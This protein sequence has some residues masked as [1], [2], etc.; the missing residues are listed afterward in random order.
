MH[1]DTH[2][3]PDELRLTSRMRPG[4]P[5]PFVDCEPRRMQRGQ[6]VSM[7]AAAAMEVAAMGVATLVVLV[8][9]AAAL[10]GRAVV[11]MQT[12]VDMDEGSVRWQRGGIRKPAPTMQTWREGVTQSW[13]EK[14]I[15]L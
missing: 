6:V 12:A 3:Q 2:G 1:R 7:E 15:Q 4:V 10:M 9:S 14:G 8:G 11:A 13:L 5:S